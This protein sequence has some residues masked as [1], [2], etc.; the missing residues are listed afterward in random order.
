MTK[1]MATPAAGLTAVNGARGR[2]AGMLSDVTSV[3]IRQ[4]SYTRDAG[5]VHRG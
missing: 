1:R 3:L 5:I 2:P 4:N